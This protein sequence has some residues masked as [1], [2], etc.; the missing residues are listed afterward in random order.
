M[1]PTNPQLRQF[2]NQFF[3]DEE[4]ETLCFDYFPEALNEFGGGMSKNR[5]IIV[6]IGHCERRGRLDDLHAA[7]QRERDDAWN[8]TFAPQFVETPPPA[9]P[10]RISV[11]EREPESPKPPAV[12]NRRIHKKTGIELVQIPAGPFLFGSSDSDPMARRNEK[13]QRTID[14]PEYWIGRAPV[15]N[16]Q[17]KR[18]VGATGHAAPQHWKGNEP[19]ADKL[20]HPVVQ[21]SWDD[22]KAFC[23]WAGLVLPTE[24]QWE[25]A[26]RGTDGRIWPWGDEEPTAEHCNFNFDIGTTTPVG[27]YSP[28]GDS[29]YGCTDMAGNVWEWTESWYLEWDATTRGGSWVLPEP[30]NRVAHKEDRNPYDMDSDVG[31]RVVELL[32][33]S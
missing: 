23:D 2:I 19:P 28:R 31:F 24:E 14:L 27:R 30:E 10:T 9:S 7:L 12:P 21:V 11:R 33:E 5:K 25:K 17:Y 4:M 8:R 26:A 6:L 22:A 16:V 1:I 20:D 32:S 29:P 15:T 13:P 18:F 3:S